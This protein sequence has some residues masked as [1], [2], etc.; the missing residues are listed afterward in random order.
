MI[1][2]QCIVCWKIYLTKNDG[3]K[4]ISVSHGICSEECKKKIKGR[5]KVNSGDS[6]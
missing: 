1:K 2:S 4:E 6:K 3:K 5:K